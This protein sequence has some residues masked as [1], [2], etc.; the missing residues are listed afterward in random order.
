MIVHREAPGDHE[1]L[2]EL[3]KSVSSPELIEAL[4]AWLPALPFVALGA[5][6]EVVGHAPSRACRR[7]TALT[8]R[9]TT[10]STHRG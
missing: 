3:F 8:P 7:R 10:A 2:G 4:R 9:S 6:G 5:A 1:A